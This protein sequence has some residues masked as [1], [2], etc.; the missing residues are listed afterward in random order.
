MK[1]KDIIGNDAAKKQL[2][3]MIDNDHI[4]HALLIYGPQGIGKLALARAAA[5]Y[6][7]CE[8]R[9]N[10][11][12][13]GVCP[14]C[15]QH[16]TFNHADTFFSFPVIK[17]KSNSR[18]TSDDYINEWKHFLLENLIENYQQWLREL[19]NENAQP[20]IYASESSN[21]ITKMSYASYSAKYKV[22][23]L[24]LPEKMNEECANK[25]LKIIEEP[26]PD[27][28]FI[29]VSDNPKE[30]LSTIFSR[31]Q[32]IEMKKLSTA[33]VAEFLEQHYNISHQDAIAVAAPADGN[34][35][36]A[37]STIA[38]DSE[39][40]E[41]FENFMVLMR[42]AYSRDLKSLKKWSENINNFKR[43][44]IK[45][46][47]QYLARMIRENYIYNLHHSELN[48]LNRSEEQFSSKFAP[49]INDSNAER[50]IA[51]IER[52]ERDIQ[53]NANGK[54]VLFDFAIKITILI[55]R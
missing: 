45:R 1:F 15:R 33:E 13:C 54:I 48:Y 44:K 42:L 34:I 30:I 37:Q 18:P 43:E 49:F 4:P 47:M 14:S 27:S 26:Y 19:N 52:T 32:R 8:H 40:K 23:I 50:M 20:Q 39:N 17:G 46:F 25:L 53:G 51:E 12:P 2:R 24:W 16:Q 22:L 5:Q 41:F 36:A 10:G 29:M 9:T 31:L 35:L 11:E 55:K 6:I 7:H 28:I 21:I 38:L 3:S